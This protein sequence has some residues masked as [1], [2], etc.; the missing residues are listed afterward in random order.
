M[1]LDDHTRRL[2]AI[3]ASISANC[4]PCLQINLTKALSEGIS[5]DQILDAIEV[6]RL[7]RQGAASK[8][9]MFSGSLTPGLIPNLDLHKDECGCSE[10]AEI[11]ERRTDEEE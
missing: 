3:G 4:Q 9:D 10:N 8:M 11:M 1:K 6:G 5:G 2:I 7:V